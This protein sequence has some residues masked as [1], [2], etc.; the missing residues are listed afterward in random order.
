MAAL[1][2][3]LPLAGS[4]LGADKKIRMTN[5]Q[6]DDFGTMPDGT[7]VKRYTL[8]N[9]NGVIAKV[10]DYGAIL[11]ELWVPDKSNRSGNVVCGFDNLEQYLKGHP[12]FG[13]TTGRYANRIANGRF[14]LR[15][16][17]YKLA[18]NNGPNHLHGGLKGFDK[19]LWA[20]EALP[21]KPGQ[22]SVRFTYVSKDGEEG[23]PGNLSVTVIYT[24]TDQN[25]LSIQYSAT[26]DQATVVNLTNHSYFNLAGGGDI[27]DHIVQI[28]ADRYTPVNAQLIPTGELASVTGTALDFQKPTAIGERIQQLKPVPGGY[29]HNFVLKRDGNGLQFAGSVTDPGSGRKVEVLTTEPGMQLYTGNFLD[30]KLQGVNGIT[31]KQHSAL[32]LE[33]QHFPDSPNQSKFPGTTLLP[34]EVYS[35]TTVYRFS[36]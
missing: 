8:K 30:G 2:A 16:K 5:I 21:A 18:A 19:Q 23:Y 17:E 3:I 12:F 11:T 31:Y 33:T 24:L 36:P 22:Q 27:L 20:S 9:R 10:M 15:G 13:A 25:E 14:T 1:V 7:V 4:S 32:C 35:T 26:T 28:A 29:D 6:H 34:G